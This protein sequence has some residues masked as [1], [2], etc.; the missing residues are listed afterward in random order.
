MPSRLCWGG[1]VA[2]VVG[3]ALLAVVAAAAE[4][5]VAQLAEPSEETPSALNTAGPLELNRRGG[6]QTNWN[7]DC[8]NGLACS[9]QY[10]ICCSSA[11]PV[12]PYCIT[13]GKFCCSG[14]DTEI[15]GCLLNETCC[16]GLVPT[17]GGGFTSTLS[18]CNRTASCVRQRDKGRRR[19]GI[20]EVD[21]CREHRSMDNCLN[22]TDSC[23]WCCTTNTCQRQQWFCDQP[24]SCE[25]YGT[26]E[27]LT[28][29][30][31]APVR[32]PDPC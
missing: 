27:F 18:C 17:R 1:L 19:W 7:V 16:D 3:M 21:R 9:D 32:C 2:M 29:F 24:A 26:C 13:A 30:S 11:V 8:G 10:P 4:G 23:G 20:C 15:G 25:L 14:F 31:P 22:S 5:P 28:R 6:V 12:E